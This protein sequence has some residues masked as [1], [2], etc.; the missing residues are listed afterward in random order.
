M[1]CAEE[2]GRRVSKGRDFI[3]ITASSCP[4][5]S[6]QP[7]FQANK[8]KLRSHQARLI[9]ILRFRSKPRLCMEHLI[10]DR[11][12]CMHYYITFLAACINDTQFCSSGLHFKRQFH[13]F[14]V[15]VTLANGDIAKKSSF[16]PVAMPRGYIFVTTRSVLFSPSHT[17]L[18]CSSLA[19]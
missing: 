8:G 17:I 13:H 4:R 7:H 1:G 3:P 12:S 14:H 19:R 9:T 6:S 2:T 5:V 18:N 10:S 16:F 15:E 11:Q